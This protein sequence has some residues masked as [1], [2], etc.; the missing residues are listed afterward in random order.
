MNDWIFTGIIYAILVIIL[1][2]VVLIQY[3]YYKKN[4]YDINELKNSFLDLNQISF[5]NQRIA[6]HS[7]QNLLEK[8]IIEKTNDFLQQRV[9]NL[10]LDYSQLQNKVKK[11]IDLKI[12]KIEKRTAF[13]LYLA[14]MGTVLGL[15][16]SLIYFWVTGEKNEFLS[17]VAI[18]LLANLFGVSFYF[19]Q[20]KDFNE[21]L[22]DFE[23]RLSDYWSKLENAFQLNTN[24][25]FITSIEILQKN[26]DKFNKQFDKTLNNFENNFLEG[27]QTIEEIFQSNLQTTQE[28]NKV[29]NKIQSLD[30]DKIIKGNYRLL[31]KIEDIVEKLK[32]FES[33]FENMQN[34]LKVSEKMTLALN[35]AMERTNNLEKAVYKFNEATVVH[36][37]IAKFLK[38]NLDNLEKFTSMVQTS[39]NQSFEHFKNQLQAT[40]QELAEKFKELEENLSKIQNEFA[41]S[42]GLEFE[43]IIDRLKLE[44]LQEKNDEFIK[45]YVK[46][47]QDI[48]ERLEGLVNTTN[49]DI[50]KIIKDFERGGSFIRKGFEEISTVIQG[51]SEKFKNFENIHL[52]NNH[53]ASIDQK[54]ENLNSLEIDSFVNEIKNNQNIMESGFGLLVDL[55]KQII[56]QQKQSL[57]FLQS[58]N[59]PKSSFEEKKIANLE[60]IEG[61]YQPS[62][63]EQKTEEETIA[64]ELSNQEK[65]AVSNHRI[66]TLIQMAILIVLVLILG[67]LIYSNFFKIPD[68]FGIIEGT[69][70]LH[71]FLG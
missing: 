10:F 27:L 54:M 2:M 53:L 17:H 23:L 5:G 51:L 36:V 14:L 47:I 15:F 16:F 71:N 37:D 69:K 59:K 63:K 41:K 57:E 65:S 40:N 32:G 45:K 66:N 3:S 22:P 18:T 21:V 43:K 12:E 50:D 64:T 34:I 55:Q 42:L 8:N 44:K 46:Q 52:I 19:L 49:E 6:Y 26:L 61:S 68:K 20:N 48:S 38:D 33:W 35:D 31:T 24:N 1:L 29:V 62:K 67:V 39:A 9:N 4:G 56:E 11:I 70:T 60:V 30:L 58:T 28:L 13:P 25:T 7:E